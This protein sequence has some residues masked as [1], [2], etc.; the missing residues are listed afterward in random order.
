MQHCGAALLWYGSECASL[1]PDLKRIHNLKRSSL[2]RPSVT[3]DICIKTQRHLRLSVK[4]TAA[5]TET[6][7]RYRVRLSV[8]TSAGSEL[9]L[10]HGLHLPPGLLV[11]DSLPVPQAAVRRTIC[12]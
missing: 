12:S 4:N 1:N 9:L 8:M 11:T 10:L 7:N 6:P 2:K 3:L 5:P